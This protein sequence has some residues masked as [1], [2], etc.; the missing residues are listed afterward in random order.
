MSRW[1]PAR[2]RTCISF[3]TLVAFLHHETDSLQRRHVLQRI[4]GNRHEIRKLSYLHRPQL[5]LTPEQA[6]SLAGRRM[7]T[8]I[9][10]PHVQRS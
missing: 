4:T 6:G 7:I 1:L 3:A 9:Q 10:T 8:G 2:P 5:M